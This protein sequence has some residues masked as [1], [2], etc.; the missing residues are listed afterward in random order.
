MASSSAIPSSRPG[1]WAQPLDNP[2]NPRRTMDAL[3]EMGYDSYASVLDIVD[4][5]ID[6]QATHVDV[7][8]E[9]RAGDIIISILDNGSGM[10]EET[11]SE[12]L[13]LGSDTA[14]EAGDLGKFGM[15]LVTAS[16]GLSKRLEVLTREAEGQLLHGAFD[17]DEIERSMQKLAFSFPG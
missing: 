9:E 17:L 4:N 14:R 1:A 3:R 7:S 12:A 6:A 5:A 16:I 13:R 10:D 2:P 8:V 15:G 11:L